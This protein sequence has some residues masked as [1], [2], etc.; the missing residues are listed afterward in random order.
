MDWLAICF[1]TFNGCVGVWLNGL[2]QNRGATEGDNEYCVEKVFQLAS[3]KF[4]TDCEGDREALGIGNCSINI[5]DGSELK[6]A[7]SKKSNS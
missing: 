7:W 1:G 4:Y 2:R 6:L 3:V 5:W